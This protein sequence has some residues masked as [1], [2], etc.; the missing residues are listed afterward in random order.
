MA[1]MSY[2]PKDF[3]NLAGIKGFSEQLM[4][5]HLSLYQ[6]YVANTN[7][8][9][10]DLDKLLKENETGAHKFAELK[11]RFGWEFNGMKLH[12]HYFLNITNKFKELDKNSKFFREI[13]EYFGSYETWVKDFK[14]VGLMRGIGWVILYY[15]IEAKKFFNTWI[16]EHDT[17]HLLGAA[18]ILVMDMFEHAFMI[19]YGLKKA[20]YIESFFK[21]IDWNEVAKR[22]KEAL[23]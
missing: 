8:L 21:A 2:E 20:E 19:D 16:N 11:R 23:K 1:K 4:K 18:P 17:S 13:A 15:D 7:K 6:G 5:N 3:K 10:A 12:E 9:I 22:F 14:S